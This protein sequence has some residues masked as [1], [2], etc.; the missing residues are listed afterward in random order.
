MPSIRLIGP[1][2]ACPILQIAK[3]AICKAQIISLPLYDSQIKILTMLLTFSF[4]WPPQFFWK[5]SNHPGRKKNIE[6]GGFSVQTFGFIRAQG[7]NCGIETCICPEGLSSYGVEYPSIWGVGGVG[8]FWLEDHSFQLS[9]HLTCA[10][11]VSFL[12]GEI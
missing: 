8:V 11:L 7:S 10:A 3:A 5:T 2:V 1:F 9:E 12:P 4:F 6:L